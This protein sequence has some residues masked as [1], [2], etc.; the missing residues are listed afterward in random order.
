MQKDVGKDSFATFEEFVSYAE[1]AAVAP[2]TVFM[3]LLTAQ[4]D[5]HG[6]IWH[7]PPKQIQAFA[8]ELALFCYL[9]HVIRDVSSDL[10]LGKSGLLYLSEQDLKR[11][12]LT[13]KD[14]ND[15]RNSKKVNANFRRLA[16]KYVDRARSFEK[17]GRKLLQELNPSLSRDSRF[18]LDLLLEFYAQTLNKI[19]RVKYNVFSGREKLTQIEEK[20]LIRK[21]A[22]KWVVEV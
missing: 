22:K 20:N 7:Y 13:K 3:F 9:T 12:R 17:R 11:Y 18:I 14:L 5:G 1:G 15:F 4:R 8:R 2:A 6:Y 16:A 21:V 19:A 10:K